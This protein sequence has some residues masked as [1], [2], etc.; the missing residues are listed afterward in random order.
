MSTPETASPASPSPAPSDPPPSSPDADGGGAGVS[1]E[2]P[3]P[4]G[5]AGYSPFPH[6]GGPNIP[7][8]PRAEAPPPV[9]IPAGEKPKRG[10]GRPKGSKNKTPGEDGPSIVLAPEN[11]SAPAKPAEK[12]P[13]ADLRK[14]FVDSKRAAATITLFMDGGLNALASMRYGKEMVDANA[15]T[16]AEKK[17]LAAAWEAFLAATGT[18]LSPGAALAL[19]IGGVYGVRAVSMEMALRQVRAA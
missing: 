14:L 17:E 4:D 2:I 19:A 6:G 18:Q 16:E 9:E 10:P 13:A 5:W 11:V 7:P 15:A 12:N 8:P 3:Q 1:D